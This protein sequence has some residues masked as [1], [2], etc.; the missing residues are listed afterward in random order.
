MTAARRFGQ[1]LREARQLR[2]I[3]AQYVAIETGIPLGHLEALEAGDLL[4]I[5]GGMY[6]RAEVRAYADAVG[7]DPRVVLEGLQH[8]LE[9]ERGPADT[10]SVT[11]SVP[12][13]TATDVSHRP[14]RRQWGLVVAFA[15]GG[16]TLLFEQ[17]STP[18]FLKEWAEQTPAVVPDDVD[19]SAEAVGYAINEPVRADGLGMSAY[20]FPSP[21]P[22]GPAAGATIPDLRRASPMRDRGSA[23]PARRPAPALVVHTTPRGARVTV[24]GIGWGNTPAVIRHLPAGVQR[25][26]VVKE[27]FVTE[28]RIVEL[29]EGQSR[30]VAIPLR[31]A[32]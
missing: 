21:T 16:A 17:A 22:P 27:Q 12:L 20:A 26:R 25:V 23:A 28:E 31:R 14:P 5:P 29:I 8:A 24:N 13:V 30:R 15:L 9:S 32:R 6:R 7:L 10:P 19:A 2:G 18:A 4:A 3:S 11:P 1:L